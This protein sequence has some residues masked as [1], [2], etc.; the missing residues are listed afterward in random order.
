MREA[1]QCCPQDSRG[2]FLSGRPFTL[3]AFLDHQTQPVASLV[4]TNQRRAS[5]ITFARSP[6][7]T[8]GARRR[9]FMCTR[10]LPTYAGRLSRITINGESG[11]L[12]LQSLTPQIR[13]CF[14]V[15]TVTAALTAPSG[16][17]ARTGAGFPVVPVPI[18]PQVFRYAEQNCHQRQNTDRAL[19]SRE[20]KA[21][22]GSIVSIWATPVPV[23]FPAT[24][25][26]WRPAFRATA[27]VK[28]TPSL[29][30]AVSRFNTRARRLEWSMASSGSIS[31]SHRQTPVSG[32]AT[33]STWTESTATC[34]V[35][36][37]R[38]NSRSIVRRQRSPIS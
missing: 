6:L 21:K 10:F 37:R 17:P 38:R 36:P 1:L 9:A 22:G 23:C 16:H 32:A 15:E 18:A 2:V 12:L 31:R 28:S 27:V 14:A 33:I 3:R 13:R 5:W 29:T 7:G 30:A 11:A 25:D 34:S 20:N 35:F 24:M 26:K 8:S 19:I 4:G